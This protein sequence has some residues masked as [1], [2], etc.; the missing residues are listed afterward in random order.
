MG[1]IR[2]GWVT[3]SVVL[4]MLAAPLLLAS[5]ERPVFAVDVRLVRLLV[6]VKNTAGELIAGLDRDDFT[7]IDTG[8][9]QKVELF[10]RQTEQ[11]LS[12]AL[13]IDT[14]GSTAIDLGYELE[15]ARRFLKALLAEGHPEDSAALYTF[16]YQVS[17]QSAF[18]RRLA[19]LEERMKGL[20]GEAGTSLYDAIYLASRDL[21][22]RDGRR[23]IVVVT[24]GGDTTSRK[25]FHT[26]LASAHRAE[27]AL[28]GILVMPIK[29]DVG[30]NIGGEN[31]LSGLASSTG[32][33]VFTPAI[34]EQLDRAFS[35]IL[36]D[37]RTQYLI[38]YYP[39]NVPPVQGGFHRVQVKVNRPDLRVQTRSG[40]YEDSEEPTAGGRKKR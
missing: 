28:Y 27:A 6:T 21:E 9:P 3:A 11:P 34:G 14:S 7:V 23:V 33:R 38:G 4:A 36:R 40:Y 15:S 20:R 2:K 30:R 8:V 29:S 35:E 1:R 19:R 5:Q 22:G 13:L 26:A 18:T 37:L 32:G 16:N 17:L 10:E 39:K 12:V 31:A 25:D 24:D